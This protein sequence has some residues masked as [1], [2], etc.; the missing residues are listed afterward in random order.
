[1][2]IIRNEKMEISEIHKSVLIR[3]S[4][5]LRYCKGTWRRAE[6]GNEGGRSL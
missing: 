6:G 5:E 4:D 2:D 3:D 1:M